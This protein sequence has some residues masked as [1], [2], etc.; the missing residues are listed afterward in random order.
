MANA[1]DTTSTTG[2]DVTATES[3][4]LDA[5][6]TAHGDTTIADQVVQKIAGLA[7]R[8]VE[9]VWAMGN[10]AQRALGTITGRIQGQSS[11][12]T[13]GVAIEKGDRET[14]VD[15][16]VIVEYGFAIADVAQE[17]RENVIRA[18]EHGT[19]LVVKSVDVNVTDVHLPN[20]DNNDNAS[21]EGVS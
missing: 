3:K 2:T 11:N 8:E 20:D 17:I 13:G 15:V 9:G 21:G 6:H 5:L 19:G 14:A 10:V 4:Q 18:V 7:A 1:T 16:S 12:I